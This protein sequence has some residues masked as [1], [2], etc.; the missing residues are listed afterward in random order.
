VHQEV[1]RDNRG[2]E[3]LIKFSAI[4]SVIG[5]LRRPCEVIRAMASFVRQG[6]GQLAATALAAVGGSSSRS[7]AVSDCVH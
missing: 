1:D 5:C 2:L 4:P 6:S 3:L 7:A